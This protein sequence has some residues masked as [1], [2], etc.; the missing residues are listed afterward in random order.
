[1]ETTK[2]TPQMVI[3]HLTLINCSVSD[4]NLA[5]ILKGIISQGDKL[6]TFVYSQNEIGEKSLPLLIKLIPQ[7]NE[8]HINNVKTKDNK[9][10]MRTLF[11]KFF[12]DGKNLMK[13]KVSNVNLNDDFVVEEI[14]KIFIAKFQ[15]FVTYIELSACSFAP[16]QMAKMMEEIRFC[17]YNIRNLN[18]SYNPLCFGST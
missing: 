18:L 9:A 7:L 11:S 1:M 2:Q 6:A 17:H 4:E 15:K 12:T 14:C 3:H 5:L 16:H 8:V 13:I 10:L